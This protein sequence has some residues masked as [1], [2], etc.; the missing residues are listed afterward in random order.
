MGVILLWDLMIKLTLS[1]IIIVLETQ[2]FKSFAC[3]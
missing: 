2:K 1:H 3:F